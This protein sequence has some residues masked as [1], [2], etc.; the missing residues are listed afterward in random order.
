MEEPISDCQA[1]QQQEAEILVLLGL[2]SLGFWGLFG[3][4]RMKLTLEAILMGEG[5]SPPLLVLPAEPLAWE[6]TEVTFTLMQE[7]LVRADIY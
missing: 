7:A 3:T 5:Y 2:I 1:A 4:L 6:F